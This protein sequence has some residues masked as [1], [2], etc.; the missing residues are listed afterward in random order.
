MEAIPTTADVTACQEKSK[1]GPIRRMRDREENTL[2]IDIAGRF[3]PG[4]EK[5][6]EDTST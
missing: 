3:E 4:K 1:I 2:P 6:A 5:M